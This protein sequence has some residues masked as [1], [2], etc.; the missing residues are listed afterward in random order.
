MKLTYRFAHHVTGHLI[1]F[2]TALLLFSCQN[3]LK[4]KNANTDSLNSKTVISKKS[5]ID[6]L[7]TMP[8]AILV[9]PTLQKIDSMKKADGEDFYIGA[10]D[11][12]NYMSTAGEFL[13]SVKTKTFY[14]QSKGIVAFKTKSGNIY[15]INLSNSTWNAF[16]FNGIDKPREADVTMIEEDYKAYM[17]K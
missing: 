9:S 6:T 17:L 10:D 13:D 16:L 14:K 4:E 2:F 11:Y 15:K 5:V 8:C 7:I 12:V 3:K 1:C